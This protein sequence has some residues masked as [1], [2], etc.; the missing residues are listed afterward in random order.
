MLNKLKLNIRSL[1]ESE[2]GH[3][4]DLLDLCLDV[5]YH[6][7]MKGYGLGQLVMLYIN[8]NDQQEKDGVQAD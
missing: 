8:W 7:N 2:A 4:K 1:L 6:K 3:D 5:I